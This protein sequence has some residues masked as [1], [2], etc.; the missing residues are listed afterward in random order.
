MSSSF[1][2]HRLWLTAILVG[3][4][5][6]A[7]GLPPTLTGYV[8]ERWGAYD[9]SRCVPDVSGG[10]AG[11]ES[12]GEV[13]GFR[14]QGHQGFNRLFSHWQGVQR[15]SAGGGNWLVLTRSGA[16][17]G[18]V[19]VRMGSRPVDGLAWR[20]NRPGPAWAPPDLPPP[21]EDIE[22]ETLPPPSGF[23]H[24]G[25][26]G[27]IGRI[28][29]VPYEGRGSVIALYDMSDPS[30]PRLL[31]AFDRFGVARPS[32]PEAASAVGITKLA[33]G[34]YLMVVGAF[35]SKVLD[36]Y[37]SEGTTLLADQIAFRWIQTLRGAVAGGF[38]NLSLITQC[39]GAIFLVGTHNTSL[40]PPALGRDFVRW[41]RLSSGAGGGVAIQAAGSR[42]MDCSR[43]NFAAAAG[44]YVDPA[45]RLIL[46]ATE[47]GASGPGGSV[48]FEEFRS[49]ESE[50]EEP[51]LAPAH[52]HPDRDE[53]RQ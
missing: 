31:H 9:V 48:E 22:G 32:S 12:P 30:H 52:V 45:G 27:A 14:L 2:L 4:P 37:L 23:E 36:F 28:L 42:H 16:P 38:Q 41:Y 13:L 10:L 34:R 19:L 50:A 49:S 33:D 25:G 26:L 6:H 11:L 47:H 53:T 43:C 20:S 8:S 18:F 46:Y 39:D 51:L 1:R 21:A 44:L 7:Q 24:G 40:P 35:S 5:A 29:V 17:V 15:L 3:A